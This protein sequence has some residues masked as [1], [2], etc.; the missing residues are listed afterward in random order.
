[1]TSPKVSVCIIT[2]NHE[3]YIRE[4]LDGVLM[5]KVDFPMEVL[6]HDD[7]ST[8][9]TVDILQEY[10]TRHPELIRLILQ[11]ENQYQKGFDFLRACV[12]PLTKGKYIAIC[13][14]DDYWTDITKLKRQFDFME[15]NN[16]YS[17]CCHDCEIS[18]D[19]VKHGSGYTWEINGTFTFESAFKI[20]G[21]ATASI[22]VRKSMFEPIIRKNIL[23]LPMSEGDKENILFALSNGL[24][25]YMPEKM[26]MKRKNQGSVSRNSFYTK[27]VLLAGFSV[28]S[29]VHDFSPIE[30][31]P[32]TQSRLEEIIGRILEK[33]RNIPK[34]TLIT[35]ACRG[36]RL[37]PRK[38]SRLIYKIIRAK[39]KR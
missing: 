20:H 29:R 32:L 37:N 8:D 34:F 26:S 10:H 5:Q 27:N 3:K 18:F 2:Y 12:L 14:G 28:W 31:K 16:S 17:L 15:L 1:M 21:I 38:F 13:E 11:E 33:R 6:I 24:G 25:F 7:A 4:C 22:F 30:M 36:L 35:I 9:G 19:G 39:L 23:H